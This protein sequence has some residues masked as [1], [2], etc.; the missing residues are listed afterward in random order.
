MRK[1]PEDVQLLIDGYGDRETIIY[2]DEFFI[3]VEDPKHCN[4]E[5]FYYTAWCKE[6]LRS[7]LDI[8]KK[9]IALFY[10]L[11]RT[12]K[13]E[14]HITNKNSRQLIHFPPNFWRLHIHIISNKCSIDIRCYPPQKHH[15]CT[16]LANIQTCEEYYR[17]R[18]I[19]PR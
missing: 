15:L 1:V 11:K 17:N 18:A 4:N 12:L 7:I 8:E 19:I 6:D 10:I 5:Y 9:H 16:V 14:Y 3:V 13:T 2:E